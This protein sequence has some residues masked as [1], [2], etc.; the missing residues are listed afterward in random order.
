MSHQTAPSARSR[1]IAAAYRR[2]ASGGIVLAAGNLVIV[3]LIVFNVA[4]TAP[5]SGAP[6]ALALQLAFTKSAFRD[7][8]NRWGP[9]AVASY[10]DWLWL[11]YLFPLVYAIFLSSAIATLSTRRGQPPAAAHRALFVLPF[12]AVP[13]DTLENTLHLVLLRDPAHLAAGVILVA[14]VA[15]AIKWG[16]IACSAAAIAYWF[17]WRL[18]QSRRAA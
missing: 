13:F 4:G 3:F 1:W 16:L 17:V 9:E 10:R 7:V 5:P 2:L 6:G 12:L 14:S 8:L 11:D 18:V 15:A